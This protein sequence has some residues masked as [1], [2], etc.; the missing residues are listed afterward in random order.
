MS[1]PRS[2]IRQGVLCLALGALT[3]VSLTGCG[4]ARGVGQDLGAAA[5]AVGKGFNQLTQNLLGNDNSSN[6]D[7]GIT[8]DSRFQQRNSRSKSFGF[9]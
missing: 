3:C 5:N 1:M 2:R 6:N 8:N 4:T 7:P 9:H